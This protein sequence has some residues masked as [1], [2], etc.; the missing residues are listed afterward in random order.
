M[1][2]ETK[3]I[4]PI[5][6]IGH[7]PNTI[8]DVHNYLRLGANAIEPDINLVSGTNNLCV[9]HDSGDANTISLDHYMAQLNQLLVLYPNLSLIYLDC[10]PSVLGM[11][12][13][14]LQ[15]V[16]S[17]LVGANLK[18]VISVAKIQD[19]QQMFPAIVGDLKENEYLLI[20]EEND[21]M[22]VHEFFKS[23]NA[24]RFGYGNGDS[25]PLLP[26]T[27]FFPHIEGSINQACMLRTQKEL[28]F[29]F[30]W[31]FN[32]TYNQE[33]FL[34]T[35]VNGIIVDYNGFPCMPGLSNIL[36]IIRND[37]EYKLATKSDIL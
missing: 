6:V 3:M 29:V 32:S 4:K 37:S 30:T 24:P 34:K 26:T 15:S 17:N 16:R 22:M 10:K 21:P 27:I 23:I 14:I 33:F 5:Y 35:G 28:N 36:N 18:I 25:V 12:K 19:A 1:S 11:G 13:E 8:E 20:D 31:T 2:C 7:N 9:S